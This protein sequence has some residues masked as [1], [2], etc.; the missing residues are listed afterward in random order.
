MA[1]RYLAAESAARPARRA[2]V[3]EVSEPQST[4][5]EL[6]QP[7]PQ[8]LQA[9]AAVLVNAADIWEVENIRDQ[10]SADE[11]AELAASISTQGLLQPLTVRPAPEGAE[12][13]L[14]YELVYGYRRKAAC[15]QL[16][17]RQ[18]PVVVREL[19]DQQLLEEMITENLQREDLSA[20]AEARAMQRLKDTF[21]LSNRQVAE[22][23]GVHRSQ[24]G[25]RL[26]LLELPAAVK[27][28]V[29]DGRLTA[30]HAEVLMRLDDATEQQQVA[31]L[32]VKSRASV[33]K[34]AGYVSGIVAEKDRIAGQDPEPAEPLRVDDPAVAVHLPDFR[35]TP[36]HRLQLAEELSDTQQLRAQCYTL[37]A[38][39]NDI[40]LQ[41]WLA[42]RHGVQR[43]DWWDYLKGL[44]SAELRQLR[45]TLTARFL[46]AAHRLVS[47]PE[48]MLSELGEVVSE[49]RPDPDQ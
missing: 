38:A 11:L 8:A 14:P 12:H 5:A 21:S 45:W 13:E 16:G 9:E 44:D 24:V 33:D 31:E 15:E 37:L 29:E 39:G 17:H 2:H 32:A 7:E 35:I 28:M 20:L 42:D 23:L 6:Q 22:R 47:F 34:L 27:T 3:Q 36:L 19:S 10:F 4:D 41:Q 48:A 18:L 30:S 26:A 43:A 49:P 1:A 46:E 25:K 40:E